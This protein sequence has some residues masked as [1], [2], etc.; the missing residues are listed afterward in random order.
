MAD[1]RKGIKGGASDQNCKIGDKDGGNIP[2]SSCL[3]GDV[4]DLS[5]YDDSGYALRYFFGILNEKGYN[6][7][8]HC[9]GA[10]CNFFLEYNTGNGDQLIQALSLKYEALIHI[11]WIVFNIFAY[12]N[13]G[14]RFSAT[15]RITLLAFHSNN[16][17]K[18]RV[19]FFSADDLSLYHYADRAQILV[20]GASEDMAHNSINDVLEL[21]HAMKIVQSL[22]WRETVS[23]DFIAKLNGKYSLIPKIVVKCIRSMDLEEFTSAMNA[24][25]PGYFQSLCTVLACYMPD[26]L[27]KESLERLLNAKHSHISELLKQERLVKKHSRYIADFLRSHHDTAELLLSEYAKEQKSGNH[28][29]LYFPGHLTNADRNVI[30]SEYLDRE[31]PNLNYVTLA[32][33]AKD[34][35]G[36]TLDRKIKYKASK[37]AKEL[38]NKYL[39]EATAFSVNTE[40]VATDDTDIQTTETTVK[41]GDWK[42]II[43]SSFLLGSTDTELIHCFTG[44]FGYYDRQGF[45]QMTNKKHLLSLFERISLSPKQFYPE[46][47]VFQHTNHMAVAQMATVNDLLRKNGRSIEHAIKSFYES[48]LHETYDYPSPC[49]NVLIKDADYMTKLKTI[50]PEMEAVVKQYN[51]YVCSGEIDMEY[52]AMAPPVKLTQCRSLLPKKNIVLAEEGSELR[53]VM[54]LFFSDQTTLAYVKPYTEHHYTCLFD[55]LRSGNKVLYQNYTEYQSKQIDFLISKTYLNKADSGLLTFSNVYEI[56]TLYHLFHSEVCSYWFSSIGE[57]QVLDNYLNKGWCNADSNLFAPPEQDW[58][59]YYLNDERFVNAKA[60]RNCILHGTANLD[61][62]DARYIYNAILMIFVTILL[63]IEQDLAITTVI[64]G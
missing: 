62:T 51:E 17:M 32:R 35:A 22:Q 49:L 26:Y 11:Y 64:K 42:T 60:Y 28:T 10:Q 50:L 19:H 43:N 18:D 46:G 24:L 1:S 8:Y 3:N 25:E 52:L 14:V 7:W 55:L 30:I 57:R 63:K 13:F 40:V 31:E 45:I 38:T 53:Q 54:S 4:I 27:G 56:R 33:Y 16:F 6:G 2:L 15:L 5:Q 34:C 36:L 39:H 9:G 44:T 20:L 59:S 23:A 41:D 58:L 48:Y 47:I 37:K 61:E 21:Y 12:S 29:Q